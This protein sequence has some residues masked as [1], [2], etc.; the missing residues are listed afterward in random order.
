MS[1]VNIRITRANI[2]SGEKTNPSKCA[3]ANA[4][5]DNMHHVYYVNVIPSAAIVK[6]KKGNTITAYSSP[7]PQK[8]TTFIQKFDDGKRVSPFALKLQFT[9]IDKKS[10]ELI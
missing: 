5:M 7:L 6:I 9:K 1:N 3:I 2:K 10:A 4:I 8:A